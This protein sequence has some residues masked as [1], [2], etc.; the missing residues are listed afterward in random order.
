MK[1]PLILPH[2]RAAIDAGFWLTA[3]LVVA[4]AVLALTLVAEAGR[5]LL[6]GLPA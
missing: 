3:A 5:G 2:V 4:G 6:V 1:R